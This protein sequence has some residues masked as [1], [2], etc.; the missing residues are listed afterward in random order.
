MW[1]DDWGTRG[2]G[3]QM[4]ED[5][6]TTI[7]GRLASIYHSSGHADVPQF[8]IEVWRIQPRR[9]GAGV[10]YTCLLRSLI[11]LFRADIADELVRR[12]VQPGRAGADWAG[13]RR[14]RRGESLWLRNRFHLSYAPPPA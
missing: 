9:Q 6:S 13:W 2:L 1:V 5:S 11:V 4:A 3:K 12:V 7:D 14:T 8:L 10:A